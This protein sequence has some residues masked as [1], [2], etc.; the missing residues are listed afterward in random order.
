MQDYQLIKEY[1]RNKAKGHLEIKATGFD[2]VKKLTFKA[3]G[4][5]S[6]G[7]WLNDD[8]INIY[9]EMMEK[10]FIRE[11]VTPYKILNSYFATNTLTKK[12]DQIQ[13]VVRK[14]GLDKNHILIM[15]VNNRNHW[16]F[17]VF[18]KGELAVYDSMKHNEN[19]YMENPIFKNALKF[20]R[21]FYDKEYQL[22]V[23]SDFPQQDNY[24]DCGVFMLMGIRDILRH[25]QWSYH[26]GDINFK[27]IQIVQEILKETLI[28]TD[29]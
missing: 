17:A 6:F 14:K 19:Y 5:L 25:K 28:Y 24:Y 3:V 13:R 20:A 8:V 21:T 16:Y 26:Q 1:W 10:R 4:G 12:D 23:R 15:P 2:C 9:T 22:V 29:G 18:E 7:E 27:R 11:C